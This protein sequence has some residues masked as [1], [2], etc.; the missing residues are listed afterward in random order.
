MAKMKAKSK[1]KM[2]EMPSVMEDK[3]WMARSDAETLRKAG[4][5]MGDRSRA[6]AAQAELRKDLAAVERVSGKAPS[7]GLARKGR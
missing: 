3:K 5:I 7:L 6:K 2:A 1:S 4:E